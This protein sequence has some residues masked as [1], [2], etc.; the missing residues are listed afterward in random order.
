MI[1]IPTLTMKK[2]E[3]KLGFNPETLVDVKIEYSDTPCHA[4]KKNKFCRRIK[5]NK[6]KLRE[7]M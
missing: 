3:K 5:I 1:P 2:L 7:M 4:I 6:S